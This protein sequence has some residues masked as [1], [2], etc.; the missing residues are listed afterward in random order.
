L[1]LF[2]LLLLQP[3]ARGERRHAVAPPALHSLA[4]GLI[5]L[6]TAAAAA[7]GGGF[8]A[9][10]AEC[11]RKKAVCCGPTCTAACGFEACSTS[12]VWLLLQPMPEEGGVAP[13]YLHC[14][15]R[16]D[17]PQSAVS[18]SPGVSRCA[19]ATAAAAAKCLRRREGCCGPTCTAATAAT[20]TASDTGRTAVRSTTQ[21]LAAMQG[22]G[23]AAKSPFY[24]NLF[25]LVWL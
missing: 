9:A 15:D 11:Q 1:L 19:V 3:S 2:L 7:A 6:D 21:A 23:N 18:A 14:C 22:E 12:L 13:L 5:N 25:L 17:A 10:A 8:A 4:F 20:P 16:S 24:L